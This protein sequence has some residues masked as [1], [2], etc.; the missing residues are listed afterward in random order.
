MNN[1]FKLKL[2]VLQMLLEVTSPRKEVTTQH[3]DV[4]A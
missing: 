1:N 3:N 4:S 2:G